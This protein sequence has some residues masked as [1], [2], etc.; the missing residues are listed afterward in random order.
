MSWVRTCLLVFLVALSG[1][2][3]GEQSTAKAASADLPGALVSVQ[4][5]E[6]SLTVS[7]ASAIRKIRYKMA[8]VNG[9]LT[10]ANALIFVPKSAPPAAGWP[11]IVWAHGTTGV[12]DA[13]APSQNF[14]K[15]GD[16]QVISDLLATD[17]VVIAPDY[18][19]LDAPGVHP[20]YSRSSH[21]QAVLSALRASSTLSDIPQS[22]VWAVMGH[23]QGGNVALAAAELAGELGGAYRLVGVA[24]YAPGSNFQLVSDTAFAAIDSFSRAGDIQSAA[25][26]LFLI[27]YNGAFVAHG[28]QAQI[29]SFDPAPL[30][31]L[32][33]QALLPLALTDTDCT[34]FANALASDLR[35]FLQAGNSILSY[36][37]VRRDWYLDPA[38]ARQL[39]ANSVGLVK[40]TSPVLVV[41][42]SRDFE[43]PAQATDA[44]VASMRASGNAI[45]YNLIA[46]ASHNDVINLYRAQGIAFIKNLITK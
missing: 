19:G 11:V 14:E 33:M 39:A 23:S 13:C 16:P 1:C 41:Q 42:G 18:E 28:V 7:G 15:L 2:G 34:Q 3:G 12:A 4:N 37:G 24:A 38:A 31:G 17:S 9:G 45:S 44:L 27:N 20:Y 25:Q 21:A 40:I 43:V 5:I 29:P 22:G 30:F 6:K 32:K 35:T 26:I 8:A 10:E 46:G 36:P